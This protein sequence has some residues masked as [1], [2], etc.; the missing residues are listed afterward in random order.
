MSSV[1]QKLIGSAT[2]VGWENYDTTDEHV[3]IADLFFAELYK[4]VTF[5][6]IFYAYS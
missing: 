5:P 3:H 1:W 4:M 6:S 2:R